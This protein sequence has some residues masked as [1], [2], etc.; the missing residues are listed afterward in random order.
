MDIVKRLL[1]VFLFAWF[2]VFVIN[3]NGVE[4][5]H[6]IYEHLQNVMAVEVKD[7]HRTKYH[8][9]PPHHWI[10]GKC[11]SSESLQSIS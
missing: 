3:K 10:N 9:Q 8:F 5:S 2:C 6:R 7:T 11:P 4:A 1:P